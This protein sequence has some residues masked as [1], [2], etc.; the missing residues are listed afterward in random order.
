MK[1][2]D[3]THKLFLIPTP[4]AKR[5][6][7]LVLPEHTIQTIKSLNC[8]IVEKA[9]TTQSF[10]QWIDHPTPL[11]DITFRVLNKKTPEHEIISFLKFLDDQSVGLMSEAGA[12]GVADPGSLLVKLAHENGIPV[13]PLVG[14]SSILLALMASGLNGQQFTFHG[15]LPLNESARIQ[16]IQELEKDTLKSGYTHI[17]METPH[18]NTQLFDLMVQKL[19]PSTK[20]CI[21]AGVTSAEEFIQTNTIKKWKNAGKPDFEKKPSLFLIN[22]K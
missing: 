8:F 22:A 9:Q 20:L 12:P 4:I 18:R 6:Q 16:R 15:Y 5:K 21:A 17:F 13:V 19:R 11:H 10:L 7:N 3:S 14:P 1:I 2:S